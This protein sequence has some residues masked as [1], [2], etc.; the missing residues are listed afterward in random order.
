M[1]QL[2][3]AMTSFILVY[4]CGVE[5]SLRRKN[6]TENEEEEEEE[7]LTNKSLS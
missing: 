4:S 6:T 2:T 5:T 1:F 3:E 7:E